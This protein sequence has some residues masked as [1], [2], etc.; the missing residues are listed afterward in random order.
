ME[1]RLEKMAQAPELYAGQS[2]GR[3]EWQKG[4]PMDTLIMLDRKANEAMHSEDALYEYLGLTYTLRMRH[5]QL[6]ALK[7][8]EKVG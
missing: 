5:S 2:A 7:E 6:E 4:L 1:S 3:P 8:Q